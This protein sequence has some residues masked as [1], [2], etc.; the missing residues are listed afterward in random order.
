[1]ACA[2]CTYGA[3]SFSTTWLIKCLYIHSWNQVLDI[4][5]LNHVLYIISSSAG[6]YRD[7]TIVIWSTATYCIL[8]T[9][10]A[11]SPIHDLRWDPFTVNEFASVGADGMVLFW[12]LDETGAN[13]SL[14][15]HEA[16]VP[17]DLL[18]VK[19]PVSGDRRCLISSF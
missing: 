15:V 8:T 11:A 5:S 2:L 4:H 7:C 1:M 6:D 9:S 12:L 13:V 10:K 3:W 18:Y 16:E 17:E 19:Q 14:N